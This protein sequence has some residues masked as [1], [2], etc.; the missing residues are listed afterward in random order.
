VN[1]RRVLPQCG[2]KR[3][4]GRH[5]AGR[6]RYYDLINDA[7]QSLIN[8]FRLQLPS[9]KQFRANK[10]GVPMTMIS[11]ISMGSGSRVQAGDP[12]PLSIAL[13]CGAGLLVSFCLLSLGVDLSAGWV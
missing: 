9:P 10:R 8:I 3:L 13:F 6:A 11:M 1:E 7:R 5:A 2:R 12:S 4:N